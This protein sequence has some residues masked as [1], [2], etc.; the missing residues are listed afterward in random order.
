MEKSGEDIV[1]VVGSPRSGT[2]W[3]QKLLGSHPSIVTAQESEIFTTFI[4]PAMRNYRAQLDNPS[5]RGGTGLPCYWTDIEFRNIMRCVF[6]SM[7]R[8]IP[9]YIDGKLFVEKTPSHALVINSIKIILPKAKYV[10]IIRD[11]RDVVSSMI[12]ASKS[13]GR[14]WAPKNIIQAAI[15][16]RRH[17]ISA[18]ESLRNLPEEMKMSFRYEELKKDTLSV[19]DKLYAFCG[20][21]MSN[22]ELE[23]IVESAN[24][25]TI[26]K[27]G[28]FGKLMGNNVN[29][30]PDFI[31]AKKRRGW[32]DDIGILRGLLLFLL[33][34]KEMKEFGYKW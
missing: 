8:Q 20:V 27:Y 25:F 16:W 18:A 26:K 2:T 22:Q 29:D 14:N 13:W 24:S 4:D 31:R 15:M 17:T 30:P 11:P 6:Y 21:E 1:F 10:H 9:E 5:G 12:S 7:V 33:L 19:V 32:R 3:V 34:R 28:E 23:D